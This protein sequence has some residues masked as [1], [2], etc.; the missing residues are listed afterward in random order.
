MNVYKTEGILSFWKGNWQSILQK[1]G[2]TGTNYFMFE[3]IKNSPVVR[4]FW[5]S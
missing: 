3:L 1:S 4:P 5:I 2:V